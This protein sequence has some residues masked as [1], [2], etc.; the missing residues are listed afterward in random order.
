MRAREY[1]SRLLMNS[2]ASS[3]TP[4]SLPFFPADT[5]L[6]SLVSLLVSVLD[7]SHCLRVEALGM[8]TRGLSS[9]HTGCIRDLGQVRQGWGDF[10]FASTNLI[11]TQRTEVGS[12]MCGHL[13][14]DDFASHVS[15]RRKKL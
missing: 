7:L 1:A 5:R 12:M 9:R 4:V 8:D 11:V 6:W 10:C 13:H 3:I 2:Q 14:Q 15:P